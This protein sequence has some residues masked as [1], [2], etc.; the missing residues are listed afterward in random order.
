[1]SIEDGPHFKIITEAPKGLSAYN[2]QYA[3]M[4]YKAYESPQSQ[5]EC[6][7]WEK[8][9]K[10]TTIQNPR[11]QQQETVEAVGIIPLTLINYGRYNVFT[12]F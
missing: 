10:N 9:K 6:S 11:K 3:K 1:M 5:F 7:Y 2:K 8:K 4:L 12:N